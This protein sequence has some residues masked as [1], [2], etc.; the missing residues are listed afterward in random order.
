MLTL[1]FAPIVRQ[2]LK[3]SFHSWG[4]LVALMAAGKVCFWL[5]LQTLEGGDQSQKES[6]FG[7]GNKT[8][9]K[10]QTDPR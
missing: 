6:Q 1:S 2:D 4:G 9:P 5:A 3:S 7:F 8:K 10:W